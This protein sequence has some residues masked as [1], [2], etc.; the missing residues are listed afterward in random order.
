MA[1]T[2]AASED[3]RL[4]ALAGELRVAIGRLNRRLREQAQAGDFTEA[5]RSVILHLDRDGSATVSAL[6]QAQSVRHQSMRA[7]VASLETMGVVRGEPDPADGR[8]TILS[9]TPAFLKIL[10]TGRAAKEDWLF[11]ALQAQLTPREQEGLGS[12]VKFL[13]RLADF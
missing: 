8:Q 4:S 13:Q 9:L 11:R 12:A 5:Q 7:T 3:S 6:A 10:G 1:K 2:S